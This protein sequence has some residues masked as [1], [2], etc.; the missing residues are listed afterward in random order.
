MAGEPKKARCDNCGCVTVGEPH[1]ACIAKYPGDQSWA[2]HVLCVP[3][4]GRPKTTRK[5][6]PFCG[7]TDLWCGS[8]ESAEEYPTRWFIYCGECEA[9]GPEVTP[10]KGEHGIHPEVRERNEAGA[11]A[12]WEG[13]A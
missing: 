8:N 9:R 7:G 3:C 2:P 4:G 6:C 12:A 5:P 10:A 11:W 1:E 13:R